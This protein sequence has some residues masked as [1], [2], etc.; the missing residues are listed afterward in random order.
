MSRFAVQNVLTSRWVLTKKLMPAENRRTTKRAKASLLAREFQE[1]EGVDCIGAFVLV[2][3]LDTF[4]VLLFIF[5]Y[6][7]QEL[8]Q[9]DVVTAFL[10]GGPS[11]KISM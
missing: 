1:L 11:E 7:D 4:R 3:K 6:V 10:N 2:V 9:R 8:Q 5:A